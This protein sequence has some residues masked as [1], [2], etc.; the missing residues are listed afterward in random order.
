MQVSRS[1]IARWISAA[2][3]LE[4]TPPERPQ[5]TRPSLP[6]W[7]RIRATASSTNDAIDQSPAAPHDAEQPVAEQ[8]GAARRV[9]DLGV[10]LHAVDLA[11]GVR[12]AADIVQLSLSAVWTKPGGKRVDVIAV[13]RPHRELFAGRDG[14]EH[15]LAA[16]LDADRARGRTRACRPART[17]PPS[18]CAVSCAP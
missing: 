13:R 14:A 7:A 1:P 5:I 8:L 12:E 18:S 2:A 16:L 9:H 3:T 10:E 15:A 11:R 4:S 6:T 17:L